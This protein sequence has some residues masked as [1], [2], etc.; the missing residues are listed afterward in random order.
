MVAT[1]QAI[2]DD[3]KGGVTS[4]LLRFD[5]AACQGYDPDQAEATK[6]VGHQ[7][8]MAYCVD[9]LDAT[10][11]NVDLASVGIALDASAAFLPAA[12]MLVGLWQRYEV[13]PADARARS[14][15]IRWPY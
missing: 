9:D 8:I 12:A 13:S 6:L 2:L 11:A 10:L 14:M 7:G 5:A 1:N 3:L 4:L 15:P